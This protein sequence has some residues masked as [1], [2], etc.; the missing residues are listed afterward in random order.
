M[1]TLGNWSKGKEAYLLDVVNR[2]GSGITYCFL[3][4][5][6]PWFQGYIH[7]SSI[8][9]WDGCNINDQGSGINLLPSFSP[10]VTQV[11]RSYSSNRK[12]MRGQLKPRRLSAL[13]TYCSPTPILHHFLQSRRLPFNGP[14]S[15]ILVTP[16][17]RALHGL[18]CSQDSCGKMSVA[19]FLAM[20]KLGMRQCSAQDLLIGTRLLMLSC[21][22]NETHKLVDACSY[23]IKVLR[24][25][26]LTA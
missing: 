16:E 10:C 26:F 9:L 2:K 18:I 14:F 3:T 22:S 15:S 25:S 4:Y 19:A 5:S 11:V 17:T 6:Q 13:R 23:L 8:L 12:S 1:H 7:G 21:R 20:A 24:N